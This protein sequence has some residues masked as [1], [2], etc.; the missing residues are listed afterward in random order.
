[1]YVDVL[2]ISVISGGNQKISCNYQHNVRWGRLRTSDQNFI[3]LESN[4]L[5]YEGLNQRE[6]TIK[7]IDSSDNGTYKCSEYDNYWHYG[8][9]IEII[10]KG[11]NQSVQAV[12]SLFE[13]S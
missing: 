13:N 10:V 7:N 2:F 12:Q 6:I 5:K 9:Q 1:M 4:N 3:L 8:K 11:R